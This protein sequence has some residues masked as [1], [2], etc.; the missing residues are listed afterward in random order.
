MAA[1]QTS[2]GTAAET[3]AQAQCPPDVSLSIPTRICPTA[4]EPGAGKLDGQFAQDGS[5]ID[6]IIVVSGAATVCEIAS[7]RGGC[8][9]QTLVTDYWAAENFASQKCVRDLIDS[10]GGASTPERFWI[11][12]AFVATLT[13]EQIQVVATHP[14]VVDIAPNLGAPPP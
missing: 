9:E 2:A 4:R 3:T 6:V 12:D 5:P 7:C 1:P 14:H 13:W 11:V 8:P 10:V